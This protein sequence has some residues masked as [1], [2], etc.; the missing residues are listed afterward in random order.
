[1]SQES[2]RKEAR[3][4]LEQARNDLEA[5][6]DSGKTGHYEWACFQA[7][8]AAEKALKGI[9]LHLSYEPWG[10][11][12]SKLLKDF[13]DSSTREKLADL[14]DFASLLEKFYIPTR[15]PNGLPDLTPGEV[16]RHSEAEEAFRSARK[17][18]RA[19]EMIEG[20]I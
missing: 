19:S 8:Q 13:P 6:K 5:S 15:Y 16:Y 9:W 1:M 4:W 7:Q 17:I 14:M 18:D 2:N 11:S 3:R 20:E 10:H 12:L